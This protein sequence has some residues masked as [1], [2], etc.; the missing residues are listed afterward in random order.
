[1][2][3]VIM[4]S[5][6]LLLLLL[7]ACEKKDGTEG[8]GGGATT[9]VVRPVGQPTGV[10]TEAIIGPQGG[11]L[12]SNDSTIIVDIPAGALRADVNVGIELISRTLV[13]APENTSRPAYR[14]TPHGQI[15][16]KP[17]TVRFM[18]TEEEFAMLQTNA[19]G[20]AYQATD[21]RWKRMGKA[22][23]DTVAKSVSVQTTHFSD[24][25]WFETIFLTPKADFSVEVNG[26]A[27]L[28]VMSVLP[29]IDLNTGEFDTAEESYI[30]EPSRVKLPVDWRIVNGPGN[31][32]ISGVPTAASAVFKAPGAVPTTN[33][34]A[35]IEA[36]VS[37]KNRSVLLL[38]RN[39]QIIETVQPGIRLRI[40]GGP[41]IEFDDDLFTHGSFVRHG[42][43]FPFDRHEIALMI[44]GGNAR[45]LG[46]W[47]WTSPTSGGHITSFEYIVKKPAPFTHYQNFY[48]LPCPQSA[49]FTSPGYVSIRKV[50]P[51][52]IGGNW[53]TGEFLVS[54]SMPFVDN[55]PCYNKKH[56]LNGVFKLR[57][58]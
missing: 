7:Y 1:M 17:V 57:M 23:A 3:K 29:L 46:T 32:T 6:S 49:N 22:R 26:S 35:L 54:H 52:G 24:W 48:G 28:Q 44:D 36:R 15:F 41:W 47:A 55:A 19:L 9:G 40:D 18:F 45:G 42:G 14:L 27:T 12:A 51:D 39:L 25:T 30:E 16:S 56:R 37:L 20:L 11:S 38:Y 43:E 8:I 31:G 58:N 5:Y 10:L 33:N 34:P 4:I 13:D 2:N 50:V 21:G 53:V